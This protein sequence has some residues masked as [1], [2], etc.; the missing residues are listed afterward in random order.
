M[1]R[2]NPEWTKIVETKAVLN[3]LFEQT[4]N[5]HEKLCKPRGKSVA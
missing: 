5:Y 2:I 4:V 1:D 3:L